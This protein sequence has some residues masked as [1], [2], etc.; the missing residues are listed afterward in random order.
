MVLQL[1]SQ[2]HS[3]LVSRAKRH[4]L[5]IRLVKIV[6]FSGANGMQLVE[7][8]QR[9]WYIQRQMVV[10]YNIKTSHCLL[11]DTQ[12]HHCHKQT[13]S[14]QV[15]AAGIGSNTQALQQP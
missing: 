11:G 3:E 14:L 2:A 13:A 4:T 1:T 15:L 6:R 9:S 8:G 7:S 5:N 10:H 12:T